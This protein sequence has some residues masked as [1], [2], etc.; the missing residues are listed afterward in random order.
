MP[1][2]MVRRD[3]G[4]P[5]AFYIMHDDGAWHLTQPEVCVVPDVFGSAAQCEII[6]S[7]VAGFC[8]SIDSSMGCNTT[9]AMV[10]LETMNG[11]KTE[12]RFRAELQVDDDW[13]LHYQPLPATAIG[14]QPVTRYP[15]VV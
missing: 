12:N 13:Q 7:G 5:P 11:N 10:M 3:I 4:L 14:L 8:S 15:A 2:C 1:F 9:R 6:V